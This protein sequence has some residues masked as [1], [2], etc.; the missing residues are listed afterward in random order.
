[1]NLDEV[2]DVFRRV[3]EIPAIGPDSDFFACG[4]ESLLATR[5]L[6]AVAH[7]TGIELTFA[8]FVLTPTPAALV[9]R[10]ESVLP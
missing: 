3:L 9:K 8:D 5:V 2:I 1:M 7:A 4:G 6:S 10:L